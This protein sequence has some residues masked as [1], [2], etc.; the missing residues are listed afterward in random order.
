[1][2]FVKKIV[3]FV[4]VGAVLLC[5]GFDVRAAEVISS[6]NYVPGEFVEES[7]EILEFDDYSIIIENKCQMVYADATTKIWNSITDYGVYSTEE[8]WYTITQTINY[9]YDGTTVH[10]NTENCNLNV[11]CHK[12]ECEYTVDTNTVNNTS[13]TS[14]TYTISLSLKMLSWMK[15]IDVATVYADGSTNLTHTER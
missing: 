8:I 15:V 4:L 9:T 14:P 12:T 2:N 13:T 5:C 3:S 1:M 6:M 10:I 11:K 7:M